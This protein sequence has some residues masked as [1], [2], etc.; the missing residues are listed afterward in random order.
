MTPAE[1]RAALINFVH[2]DLIG[3]AHGETE[4]IDDPPKLRY[5][6]GVLFPRGSVRNESAAIGGVE[7]DEVAPTG[8]L[9]DEPVLEGD[10]REQ[11]P[12]LSEIVESDYDDV[13]TLAN[14]Y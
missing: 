6:A 5:A 8:L 14:S 10:D 9:T 13:V 3:P 4:S 1:L 7:D 12:A 2:R 11:K